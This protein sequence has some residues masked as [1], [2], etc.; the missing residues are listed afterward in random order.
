[1]NSP[2]ERYRIG[3][4]SLLKR[5][6]E[7]VDEIATVLDVSVSRAWDIAEGHRSMRVS[8][9]RALFTYL[10]KAGELKT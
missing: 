9:W 6:P 5:K 10:S 8:R 4:A 3:L 7:L 1:M 2:R